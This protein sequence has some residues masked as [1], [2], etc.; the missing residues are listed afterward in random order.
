M[1][2]FRKHWFA[3]VPL[4]ALAFVLAGAARAQEAEPAAPAAPVTVPDDFD[5]PLSTLRTFI[6]AM[7]A[8]DRARAT[9]CLDLSG[10]EKEGAEDRAQELYRV[11]NRIEFIDFEGDATLLA[12]APDAIGDATS[13]RYFPRDLPSGVGLFGPARYRMLSRQRRFDTVRRIAPDSTIDLVRGPAGRWRFSAETVKGSR[14][15]WELLQAAKIDAVEELAGKETLTIAERFESLW[16]DTLVTTRFLTVKSWQWITLLL[17]IIVGVILDFSVRLALTIISRRAIAQ[18]GGTAKKKTLQKMVRPFGL[19]AAA[20]LWLWAIRLLGLPNE[21]LAIL[22]PAVKLF[23]MLAMVW[24]AFRVTDL[25]AEVAASKAAHTHTRFDDLLIPLARKAIKV[26]IF[27]FGLIYIASSLHVPIAPLVAGLGIGGAGFAFAA[28]DT[29]EH[30][31]GSVT[32]IADRPFEVGDWV[33]IGDVEGT[34]EE[35]GF[36]S[37]RIRTFYNSLVSVP[38][39]NL[40]RAVVDNFGRR[41]YRRWSTHLNLTYDTPPERIEAFCEGVREIIRL[42]PYTRKD[43]YQSGTR[44]CASGTGSCSTCCGS[45][46]ASASSSRSRRR[47]CTRTARRRAA[48]TSRSRRRTPT[49]TRRRSTTAAARC[50]RSPRPPSGAR[51]CRRRWSSPRRRW[52]TTTTRRR[53][54]RRWA[55]ARAGSDY[56]SDSQI[57]CRMTWCASCVCAESVPGITMA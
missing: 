31:F 17:I 53:S 9:E 6:V 56:S 2:V 11:I 43:Y 26:F 37:T 16:P 57:R 4:V 54:S 42:H 21:A 8:G 46:I 15:F 44:S 18:R 34:V 12:A 38:N 20:V 30:L 25:L 49:P 32:V 14:A 10:V 55:A 5:S 39:G 28:K 47:R 48:P 13:W 23:A 52:P 22:V 41:K 7:S 3:V 33:Q 36:R 24:S 50:A 1:S 29:V 45:P 40:V 35:L 19:A 27:V 51:A